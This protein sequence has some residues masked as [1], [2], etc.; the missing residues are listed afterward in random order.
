MGVK[1]AAQ[2]K[3]GHE[4]GIS[5]DDVPLEDFVC[6]SRVH[7]KAESNEK[8]GEHEIDY[9]L[10]IQKDVAVHLNLEEV[11]AYKFVDQAELRSMIDRAQLGEGSENS[12]DIFV[13]PWFRL[14][15][16]PTKSTNSL[17]SV[18]WSALGSNLNSLKDLTIQRY[19]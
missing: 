5:P 3:L 14:I 6:L 15:V 16:T 19:L 1:R 18:W 10:I 7:Y 13:T 2:R 8:W 12:D 9:I 11:A 4:L 17:L